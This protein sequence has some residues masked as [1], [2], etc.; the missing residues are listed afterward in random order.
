MFRRL[1]IRQTHTATL[2]F[3]GGLT[4]SYWPTLCELAR[5]WFDDPQ[6][7]HGFLVPAISA[8]MLWVRR[9]ALTAGAA[10]PAWWGV[11]I[12]FAAALVRWAGAY[13]CVDWFDAVSLLP[14]LAAFALL[15]SGWTALRRSAPAIAF[16]IFMIPL[17]YAIETAVIHPM[18]RAATAVSTYLL[19]LIGIPAL[20]DGNVIHLGATDLGVV[21]ACGGL[22]MLLCLLALA[23][24]ATV[25]WTAP[26][27]QKALLL[28]SA[29]PVALASNV[30]RITITGIFEEWFGGAL[31]SR[32]HDWIGWLM[33]P[34]ALGLLW[35]EFQLAARLVRQPAC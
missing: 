27:W 20:A 17:P 16:L 14:C 30:M 24:A 29:A 1:H 32:F 5:R 31:A 9:D 26:T 2:A 7:S 23:A 10:R 13:F 6:Y 25:L 21:E 4:W 11:P 19:Q 15:A 35:L 18:K 28:L 33:M 12:L 22:R 34:L 8:A 3:A